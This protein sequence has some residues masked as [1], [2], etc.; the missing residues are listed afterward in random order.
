MPRV[1]LHTFNAEGAK[2]ENGAEVW[3]MAD[4]AALASAVAHDI[5][6]SKV[7]GTDGESVYPWAYVSALYG[8][9]TSGDDI[10]IMYLANN[11]SIDV[12]QYSDESE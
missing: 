6:E 12:W 4:P 1:T 11:G 10:T 8:W 3:E 9:L 7:P 5:R 2:S